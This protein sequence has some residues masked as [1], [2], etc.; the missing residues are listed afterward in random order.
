[1]NITSQESQVFNFFELSHEQQNAVINELGAE[2]AEETNFIIWE[3][4][5]S[6]DILPLCMFMK[7]DI[8]E[9]DSVFSM[10][11]FSAYFFKH[12]KSG[13][14]VTVTYGHW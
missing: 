7:S 10:S 4:K 3:G 12:N 5:E 11:A 9:F 14:G 6:T 13:G 1:M 8:K 2:V